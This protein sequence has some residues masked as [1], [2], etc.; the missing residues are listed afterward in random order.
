[1]THLARLKQDHDRERRE[2][3]GRGRASA[4]RTTLGPIGRLM[5]CTRCGALWDV[6]EAAQGARTPQEHE[7]VDPATFECADCRCAQII[8]GPGDLSNPDPQSEKEITR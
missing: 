1:M 4:R 2:E 3:T 6:L 5:T 8:D 7:W